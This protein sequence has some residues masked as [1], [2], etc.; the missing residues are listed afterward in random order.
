MKKLEFYFTN[1]SHFRT[2]ED[3]SEVNNYQ[4]ERGEH[5]YSLSFGQK[6]HEKIS[7]KTSKGE[8]IVIS[9]TGLIMVFT[10]N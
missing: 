3:V 4:D 1:G 9:L 6:E 7:F 5:D 8:Q 2:Y 10:Q